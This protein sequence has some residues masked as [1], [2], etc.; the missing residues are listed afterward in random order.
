M[1]PLQQN[2]SKQNWKNNKKIKRIILV[3]SYKVA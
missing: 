2:I 1:I 3:I